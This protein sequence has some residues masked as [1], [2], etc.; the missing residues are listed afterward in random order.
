[1]QTGKCK[2]QKDT[3]DLSRPIKR[4]DEI[5]IMPQSVLRHPQTQRSAWEVSES[6]QGCYLFLNAALTQRRSA[7]IVSRWPECYRPI[8]LLCCGLTQ[9]GT[10]DARLRCVACGTVWESCELTYEKTIH[11]CFGYQI[12]AENSVYLSFHLVIF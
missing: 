10:G 2:T 1:M 3:Q 6:F 11:Y 4:R 5:F 8:P 12:L 9:Q 7:V